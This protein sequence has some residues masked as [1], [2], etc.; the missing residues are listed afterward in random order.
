L[1]NQAVE[2]RVIA[3]GFVQTSGL[4]S[5]PKPGISGA[6]TL[7]LWGTMGFSSIVGQVVS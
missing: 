5:I 1:Q 3:A 4:I 6:L 7:P 2:V